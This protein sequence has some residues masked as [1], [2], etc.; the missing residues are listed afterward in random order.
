M[1]IALEGFGVLQSIGAH[2]DVF[3]SARPDVDKAARGIV[4]KCL[5]AKSLEL[6]A[7]RALYGAIHGDPFALIVEGLKDAEVKGILTRLDKHHPEVKGGSPG[8]RRAHL[9]AL[10]AARAQPAL[11]PAKAQKGTVPR[12]AAPERLSSKVMDL[13]RKQGSD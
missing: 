5:K 7:L 2:A 1:A 4:V 8:W 10:A 12:S 6:P 13:Y 9:I 3:A 11:A